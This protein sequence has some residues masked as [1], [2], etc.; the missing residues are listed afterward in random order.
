MFAMLMVLGSEQPRNS[1]EHKKVKK[2][3]ELQKDSTI[4]LCA[5]F[6]LFLMLPKIAPC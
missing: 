1:R 5:L 4:D 2:E 6:W 3:G